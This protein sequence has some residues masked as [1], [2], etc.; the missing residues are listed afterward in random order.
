MDW[1]FVFFV[2]LSVSLKPYSKKHRKQGF[3]SHSLFQ[4]FWL[5]SLLE[6]H[7]KRTH[8]HT[9][10]TQ[11]QTATQ[12]IRKGWVAVGPI[13]HCWGGVDLMI[14]LFFSNVI[15]FFLCHC[16]FCFCCL[17]LL[18]GLSSSFYTFFILCFFL[19]LFLLL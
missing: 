13:C 14:Y 6:T 1:C 3:F 4:L 12:K 2:F 17:R 9:E 7:H 16:V 5:G 8:T 18:L 19:L 11:P 10:K 15:V